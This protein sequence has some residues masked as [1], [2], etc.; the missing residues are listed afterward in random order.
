MKRYFIKTSP[1]T[2]DFIEIGNEVEWPVKKSPKRKC[3][4]H[5]GSVK[6]FYYEVW[7][8]DKNEAISNWIKF[9]EHD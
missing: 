8:E 6:G 3:R 1:E 5:G 9:L 2:G 4:Y 7:G